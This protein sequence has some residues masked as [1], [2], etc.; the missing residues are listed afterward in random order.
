MRRIWICLLGAGC[1]WLSA[2]SK[3]GAPLPVV[4]EQLPP[5]VAHVE[6]LPSLSETVAL[7]FAPVVISELAAGKPDPN[8]ALK[9]A[10]SLGRTDEGD[11]MELSFYEGSAA[12]SPGSPGPLAVVLR[13]QGRSYIISEVGSVEVWRPQPEASSLLGDARQ[14]IVAGIELKANGPG[15]SAYLVYDG[16]LRKWFS[17]EEWGK[18]QSADLDSD[19]ANELAI[20]FEGLHLH[21]PDL[22]LYRSRDGRLEKSQSVGTA[23]WGG[24]AGG[25]AVLR[26]DKRISVGKIGEEKPEL[27]FRY[28]RG[29]LIPQRP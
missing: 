5:L 20:Q 16:G 21:P 29:K 14:A 28:D 13:F 2:C 26:E 17:F 22:I 12:D 27:L 23:I 15:L 18:P 6:P 4:K 1:L 25:I 7:E 9:K 10:V 8:W 24:D 19:G 3:E 11:D